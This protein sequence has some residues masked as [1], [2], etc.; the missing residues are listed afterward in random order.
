MRHLLPARTCDRLGSRASAYPREKDQKMEN[1][2]GKS[3]SIPSKIHAGWNYLTSR[4][5]DDN[6][7][8]LETRDYAFNRHSMNLPVLTDA[9]DDVPG[10]GNVSPYDNGV[11]S[12]GT[13]NLEVRLVQGIP[14]TFRDVIGRAT[15]AT[16]GVEPG[17]YVE[18]RDADEMLK[19]GLQTA[20]E[21]AVVVFEVRG[22]SRT[23]THQ[24]VRTRKAAFHQQSQRASF[25]GTAPEVRMPESVWRNERARAA[26][27]AATRAAHQAYAIACDEDIAYQ[28]ARFILPEGTATYIMLEYPLRTFIDTYNYRGCFMFQWEIGHVFRECRRV[29]V[30]AYPWLEPHIKISCERTHGAKDGKLPLHNH[31]NPESVAHTCTFQGWES[32]EGQCPFP[33][34]RD[35]N[36]QYQPREDLLIKRDREKLP[37]PPRYSPEPKWVEKTEEGWREAE[38]AKA[39]HPSN[40]PGVR[41]KIVEKDGEETDGPEWITREDGAHEVR[42]EEA[43][44]VTCPS[45]S[46]R[47]G[48]MYIWTETAMGSHGSKYRLCNTCGYREDL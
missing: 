47:P 44:W 18:D 25:M 17:E 41:V 40:N 29:L 37:P 15:R 48:R 7:E 26:F 23:C 2:A 46:P 4:P 39:A 38:R 19:G 13:D 36:R 35:S 10:I 20:L 43:G 8:N 6:A 11:V 14:D 1:I 3:Y 9:R 24:L 31:P 16:I 33:W 21:D 30:E 32:V 5:W 34:A 22:V 42:D 27:L 28:D 12:V 45:C